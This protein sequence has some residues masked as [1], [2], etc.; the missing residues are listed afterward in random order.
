VTRGTAPLAGLVRASHPEPSLAVTA[1]GV[2]LAV[3]G[4][5]GAAGSAAVGATVLAGQLATGWCNDWVDA[6]R[7]RAA[8][9][10][11]KPVVAGTVTMEAVRAAAV[12]AVVAVVPL[13]FLSGWRAG[14]AHTGAVALAWAYDLGWKASLLSVVAYAGAFALLPAFVSLGLPGHPWPAWWVLAAGALLGSGAHLANALPDLSD[15]L[16]LGV[17]GLPQRLGATHSRLGAALLL[18]A[19]SV[20]LVL[21]PGDVGTAALVGLAVACAVVAVGLVAGRRAGSPAPFRVALA[22][23]VLDVGLLVAR[24]SSLT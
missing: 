15:D 4:G 14:L 1:V 8:G 2:A 21:G 22:L 9:R 10:A 16:V 20:V 13:A 3:A 6:D 23:A 17:R 18:L 24:G 7:D 12:T 19:A 5:R 11:E